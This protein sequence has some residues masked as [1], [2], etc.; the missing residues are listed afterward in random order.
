MLQGN[1]HIAEPANEASRLEMSHFRGWRGGLAQAARPRLPSAAPGGHKAV[2]CGHSGGV[3]APGTVSAH[4]NGQVMIGTQLVRCPQPARCLPRKCRGQRCPASL[5][6]QKLIL[7][8]APYPWRWASLRSKRCWYRRSSPT[9]ARGWVVWIDC[10]RVSLPK[11]GYLLSLNGRKYLFGEIP[12]FAWIKKSQLSI[13]DAVSEQE[14]GKFR[15]R[16]NTE[17]AVDPCEMRLDR[18]SGHK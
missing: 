6:N 3:T 18:F 2:G 13:G 15:T 11:P 9:A 17:L 12:T 10:A 14:P 5:D 16:T 7:K 1:P 4:A 8:I